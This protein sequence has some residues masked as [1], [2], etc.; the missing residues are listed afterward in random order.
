MRGA[1]LATLLVGTAA[2]AAPDVRPGDVVVVGNGA[3]WSPRESGAPSALVALPADVAGVVA[4]VTKVGRTGLQVEPLAPHAVPAC[5]WGLDA[6]RWASVRLWV[7]PATLVPVT[8]GPVEVSVGES[9][10]RLAGAVPLLPEGEGRYRVLGGTLSGVA[11]IPASAVGWAVVEA[12]TLSAPVGA[13]VLAVRAPEVPGTG[14]ALRF[15]SWA[16]TL[17]VFATTEVSGRSVLEVGDEC[18]A[19]RFPGVADAPADDEGGTMGGVVGG[20]ADLLRAAVDSVLVPGARLS[21]DGVRIGRVVWRA[22]TR[23]R[24]ASGTCW[25][26]ALHGSP[27]YRSPQ[28]DVRLGAEDLPAE[29]SPTAALWCADEVMGGVGL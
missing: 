10:L 26:V 17:P 12:R 22:V 29:D 8:R 24:P 18:V 25:R 19:V 5:T 21:W 28:S 7:D 20:P 3:R 16:R 2:H 9:T 27:P 6:A 13:G 23:V 1:A 11:S 4:K 14:G 15:A